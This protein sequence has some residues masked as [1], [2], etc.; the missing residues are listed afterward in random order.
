MSGETEK[1]YL[2]IVNDIS[3]LK[4]IEKIQEQMKSMFFA[5][6][7]HELRTPLNTIIPMTTKLQSLI[8][9]PRLKKYLTIIRNSSI[10]LQNIIEEALDMSRIENNKF[11]INNENFEIRKTIEEVADIM[12]FQI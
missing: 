5:S 2:I 10:F 7:A 1:K 6:I 12:D 8:S 9:E 3:R 11:T 4:E